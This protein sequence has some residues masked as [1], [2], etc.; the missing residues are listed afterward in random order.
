MANLPA[1][2]LN[3]RAETSL[4]QWEASGFGLNRAVNYRTETNAPYAMAGMIQVTTG[5]GRRA[6]DHTIKTTAHTGGSATATAG[7]RLSVT[8]R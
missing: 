1:T 8:F 5:H 7:P 2:R 3:V 6:W 4:R